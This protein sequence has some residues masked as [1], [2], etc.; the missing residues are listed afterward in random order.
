VTT[1]DP[2][3]LGK[4]LALLTSDHE[5][6]V[7]AAARAACAMLDR[8]GMTW[9][10]LAEQLVN[11]VPP[12]HHYDSYEPPPRKPR[13]PYREAADEALQFSID[14]RITLSMFEVNFL[15]TV[16]T[17]RGVLTA[18]Q[19]PIFERIMDKVNEAADVV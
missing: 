18:K 10:E 7:I 12:E 6:E 5:G 14:K 19:Q 8:A 13:Y 15:G 17:W 16:R 2:D 3:K 1:L 9:P 11:G 4:V